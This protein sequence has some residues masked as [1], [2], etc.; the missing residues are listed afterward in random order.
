MTKC[1][2]CYDLVDQGEKPACVQACPYRALDFGPLDE[3]QKAHGNFAGP[4][5]LPNPNI[6]Q[7]AVVYSPNNVTKVTGDTSGHLKN[8]EEL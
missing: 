7:P 1:N 8:L 4:A 5:P 6:T 3:L 2:M